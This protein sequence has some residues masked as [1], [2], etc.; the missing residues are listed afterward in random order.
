MSTMVQTF[1]RIVTGHDANGRAVIAIDEQV[2][3]SGDAGNFN[4]WMTGAGNVAGADFPFFPKDGQTLFRI[5]RIPPADPKVTRADLERMAASFFAEVGYPGAKVDTTRHPFMHRT[6]TVD[7][8]MLLS[9]KAALLVD[10]GEPVELKPFDAVIQ[11]GTNHMWVNT[12]TEDAVFMGAMVGGMPA[13]PV[14]DA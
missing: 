2:A 14:A 8:I 9:G 4:F 3:Q 10:K 11:R 7:Y 12:G 5:F 13:G 1:R 6:P